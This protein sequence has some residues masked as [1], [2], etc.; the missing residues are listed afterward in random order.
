[1][2]NNVTYGMGHTGI[3]IWEWNYNM[4]TRKEEPLTRRLIGNVKCA[5]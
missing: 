2:N 3:M 4:E 5:L 1:M